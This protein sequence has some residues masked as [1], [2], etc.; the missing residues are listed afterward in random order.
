MYIKIL[1][2]LKNK[3]RGIVYT[4]DDKEYAHISYSKDN[5]TIELND[6]D[7]RLSSVISGCP[8]KYYFYYNDDIIAAYVQKKYGA[9]E[10]FDL[11]DNLIWVLSRDSYSRRLKWC[12]RQGYS[13][14]ESHK[15]AAWG[16]II[17]SGKCAISSIIPW[18]HW[19]LQDDGRYPL[20]SK[21]DEI[22]LLKLPKFEQFAIIVLCS[23]YLCCINT[24]ISSFCSVSARDLVNVDSYT[25][26][27]NGVCLNPDCFAPR[28]AEKF[29]LNYPL[30]TVAF[31]VISIL[32]AMIFFSWS[33]TSELNLIK[34]TTLFLFTYIFAN[35]IPLGWIMLMKF[36]DKFLDPDS[37]YF[38]IT[39]DCNIKKMK[40]HKACE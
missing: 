29:M 5:K 15:Y 3:F 31:F 21:N 2:G 32:H 22:N 39:I 38:L 14:S 1:G 16:D 8:G 4:D 35:G 27:A 37:K 20:M 34:K 9:M 17:Y 24:G 18:N 36:G 7:D 25:V 30:A 28:K 6:N 10:I 40:Y 13:L 12:Y 11:N 33:F 23:R 19:I 26:N